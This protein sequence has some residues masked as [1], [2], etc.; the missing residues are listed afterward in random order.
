MHQSVLSEKTTYFLNFVNVLCVDE[1]FF[2]KLE[3]IRRMFSSKQHLA[4]EM[5]SK[6]MYNRPLWCIPFLDP[7]HRLS[8]PV[9]PL[10]KKQHIFLFLWRFCVWISPFSKFSKIL[11]LL[12]R[13]PYWASR[14][15]TYW[16]LKSYW[17]GPT[18]I[19]YMVQSL[20][21]S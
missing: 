13:I 1:S 12:N 5:Q 20:H 9:C 6:T 17:A 4:F 3:I 19:Y 11:D 15:P 18:S 10:R 2:K 7:T 21:I 16:A 14:K 8:A